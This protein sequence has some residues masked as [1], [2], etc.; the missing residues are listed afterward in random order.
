MTH[1]GLGETVTARELA[2]VV[3]VK[4]NRRGAKRKL[5]GGP[6]EMFVTN[7]PPRKNVWQCRKDVLGYDNNYASQRNKEAGRNNP[8]R[9]NAGAR[10]ST[11][12]FPE[13]LANGE[14]C[15]TFVF[16]PFGVQ[17]GHW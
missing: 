7:L 1:S 17:L 11:K 8:S 12:N 6:D 13:N 4:S 10:V 5:A 2:M 3:G 15:L 14:V 9:N 16:V